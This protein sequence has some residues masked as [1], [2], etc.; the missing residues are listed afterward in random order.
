MADAN[1]KGGGAGDPQPAER[2]G[3]T[4]ADLQNRQAAS[5]RFADQA[6]ADAA[7]AEQDVQE[8][9]IA[10]TVGPTKKMLSPLGGQEH[11]ERETRLEAL[12]RGEPGRGQGSPPG[13]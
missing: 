5:R 11:V 10:T 8:Y 2:P 4:M 6:A 13:R 1:P 9:F 7:K 12:F 3:L